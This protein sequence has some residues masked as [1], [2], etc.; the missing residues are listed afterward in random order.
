MQNFKSASKMSLQEYLEEYL[1]ADHNE[2]DKV[3]LSR[4][5]EWE[6]QKDYPYRNFA[7]AYKGTTF[8]KNLKN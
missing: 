8:E 4:R 5:H 6:T 3:Y 1:P 2:Q 7:E